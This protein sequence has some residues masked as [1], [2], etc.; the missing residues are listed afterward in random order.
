VSLPHDPAAEAVRAFADDASKDLLSSVIRDR[1]KCLTRA[2]IT[3]GLRDG[4]LAL[5]LQLTRAF[6]QACDIIEALVPVLPALGAPEVFDEEEGIYTW[7]ALHIDALVAKHP[8]NALLAE[9]RR[10]HALRL[11]VD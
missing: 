10:L 4:N 11:L 3:A 7:L 2:A 5:E 8:D 9:F 6:S 1:H